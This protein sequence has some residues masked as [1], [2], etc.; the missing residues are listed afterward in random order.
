[1]P[2]LIL[3]SRG[4]IHISL[5][6]NDI[7]NNNQSSEYLGYYENQPYR[8]WE[9]NPCPY[10]KHPAESHG[11]CRDIARDGIARKAGDSTINFGGTL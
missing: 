7:T 11:G 1:M 8:S 2:I 3:L 4:N 9:Y 10:K 6:Y 5:S